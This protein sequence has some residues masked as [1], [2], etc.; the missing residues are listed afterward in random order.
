MKKQA[1]HVF[2]QDLPDYPGPEYPLLKTWRTLEPWLMK[3][4]EEDCWAAFNLEKNGLRRKYF[5]Q[6]IYGRASTLRAKREAREIA[7]CAS[8]N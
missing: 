7:E 4:N 8:D 1:V 3:F 6:R 5:L 2:G